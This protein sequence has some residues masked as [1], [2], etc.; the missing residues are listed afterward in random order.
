MTDYKIVP[1]LMQATVREGLQSFGMVNSVFESVISRSP[2]KDN[3]EHVSSFGWWSGLCV[4]SWISIS[5]TTAGDSSTKGVFDHY[6]EPRIALSALR[7]ERTWTEEH[8]ITWVWQR[9]YKPWHMCAMDYISKG[10]NLSYISESCILHNKKQFPTILPPSF[11]TVGRNGLLKESRQGWHLICYKTS[12]TCFVVRR[13]KTTV[14]STLKTWWHEPSAVRRLYNK[15]AFCFIRISPIILKLISTTRTGLCMW[16]KLLSMIYG[17]YDR[18]LQYSIDIGLRVHKL[19]FSDLFSAF[20][21]SSGKKQY[22]TF[23]SCHRWSN[24]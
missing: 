1:K 4:F 21:G 15:S 18:S 10:D 5:S 14:V 23:S 19:L 20:V 12:R 6:M 11:R 9:H 13:R 3:D 8:M 24:Y 22:N 7:S 16:L 2:S 17:L